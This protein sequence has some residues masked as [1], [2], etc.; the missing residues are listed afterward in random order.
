M[1]YQLEPSLN[2]TEISE[3]KVQISHCVHELTIENENKSIFEFLNLIKRT[4]F[5]H[6]L[7]K[8][9]NRDT[10]LAILE[11]FME[12][13]FITDKIE[14]NLDSLAL[15][16]SVRR[17]TSI[18]LDEDKNPKSIEEL[19]FDKVFLVGEG[20]IFNRVNQ[21]LFKQKIIPITNPN[22][23]NING[24]LLVCCFDKPNITKFKE[25][26]A[27]ALKNKVPSLFCHLNSTKLTV[28]PLVIP[29]ETSC[30]NCFVHREAPNITFVEENNALQKNKGNIFSCKSIPYSYS[31][32]GSFH[33]ISQI[34]KFKN[35]A[36]QLCLIDEVLEV[37]LLDYELDI[38]P[39][40]RIPHCEDC[41]SDFNK[42]PSRAVRALV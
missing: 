30:Y 37:D 6:C 16:L 20:E 23:S 21:E 33:V 39:V 25:L 1:P 10:L 38:L 17:K 26:N 32:A 9:E 2:I 11:L 34:I 29:D 35:K 24:G 13:N 12:H 31:L 41:Y 27:L 8:H 36:F 5:P 42:T 15:D 19:D 14:K 40:I 22:L 18:P 7:N 4:D 28:G 3:N